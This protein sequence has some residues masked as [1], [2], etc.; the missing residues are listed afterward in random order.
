MSLENGLC[1][2]EQWK[3][4]SAVSGKEEQGERERVAVRFTQ[5]NHQEPLAYKV[6]PWPGTQEMGILFLTPLWTCWVTLVGQI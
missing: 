6:E 2:Q 5:N 3:R 1:K 4:Q